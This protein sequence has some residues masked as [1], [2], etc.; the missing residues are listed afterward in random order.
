MI[1]LYVKQGIMLETTCPHTPQQNGVVEREH[2]HLLK[3]ARA[4]RF[5]SSL[6]TKSWEMF[7]TATYI[8]RRL[9]YKVIENKTPYEI[10]LTQN[11]SMIT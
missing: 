11:Q 4:L 1:D 7:M 5:E 6:P 3:I 9:P 2:R 10:L 8:I